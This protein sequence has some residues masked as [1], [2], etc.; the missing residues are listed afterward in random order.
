[1]KRI[2]ALGLAVLFLCFSLFACGQ[3]DEEETVT[4]TETESTAEKVEKRYD[5]DL[6]EYMSMGDPIGVQAE[7]QD[8]TVCTEDEIDDAV[9]QVMLSGAT[10]TEK[11]GKAERYDKV[12]IS[13]S[14]ELDGV[15]QEDFSQEDY[16]VVIG[17]DAQEDLEYRLGE[18]LIGARA[19]ETRSMLY[20]YPETATYG[21]MAGKTV[22]CYASVKTVYDAQIPECT[23]EYVQGLEGFEF[24]TVAD[25]RASVREDILQEKE[26]RKVQAVWAAFCDTVEILE[27]PRAELNGYL[28]TYKAY[29]EQLAENMDMTLAE[30]LEE[31]LETDEE[32][33]LKEAEDYAKELVRNDMILTQLARTLEVTLTE[34]EYEA[35]ILE[36]YKNEENSFAS[37]EEYVE[38]YD[39]ENIRQNLIWDKALRL[40]IDNAVSAD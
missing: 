10:F 13:F 25:F 38:Y 9:F 2:F 21:E 17:L 22:T 11:S 24:K 18:K 12:K 4:L 7:F 1:M 36:Y 19:G 16:E 35:G 3:E 29:Y 5:Y 40:V 34:E 6:S 39:E 32:S 15:L 14:M 28:T 31:Y 23:D 27:Y 26:S 37:L 33:F 8:P 20:T 30:F